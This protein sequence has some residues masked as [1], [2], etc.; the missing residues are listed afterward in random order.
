MS[1]SNNTGGASRGSWLKYANIN[2]P[3][4]LVADIKVSLSVQNPGRL[5][6]ACQEKKCKWLGWCEPV[7]DDVYG[8]NRVPNNDTYGDARIANLEGELKN[9]DNLVD[10]LK[11]GIQEEFATVKFELDNAIIVVNKNVEDEVLNLRTE[12]KAMKYN[13]DEEVLSLK[14]DLKALKRLMFGFLFVM[15]VILICKF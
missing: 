11:E 7:E 10:G 1:S 5:Y 3:C 6:Y 15:A 13:V 8:N 4:R 9:L 2:C 14:T 12:L